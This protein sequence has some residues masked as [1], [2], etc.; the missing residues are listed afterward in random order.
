MSTY[1]TTQGDTFDI[2]AKKIYGDEKHIDLL[3]GANPRY[4]G[5]IVFSAGIVLSVP[6]LTDTIATREGFPSWRSGA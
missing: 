6:D 4:C 1:T 2:L 3:M 5:V